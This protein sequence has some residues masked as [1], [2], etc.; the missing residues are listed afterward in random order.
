MNTDI[1]KLLWTL[2]VGVILLVSC[3]TPS[4]DDK[5]QSE[6][7]PIL[8]W[9]S[10]LGDEVTKD[11]YV[12]MREAGFNISFSHFRTAEQVEKALNESNGTGV[13]ILMTCKE[14][15]K[16]P[17]KTVAR[18]KDHPNLIGY[19]LRDEPTCKEFD[20][21]AAWA[22]RIKKVDS[23]KLL[24]LNLFPNYASL[25]HLG[26]KTYLD[27]VKRF[28]KEVKLGL[29][30]FD[31]YPIC[32]KGVRPEFYAN[33][34][35]IAKAAK[36][37]GEPFWAFALSTAHDPYPVPT[38]AHI[39]FQIFSNLAYGAQG[40]QYFTYTTPVGSRWNFHNAPIDENGKKTEVYDVIA[41][42]NKE[43]HALT[44]VFLGAEVLNVRHTGDMIP[45]G[46]KAL[47]DG[48]KNV[49]PS[50]FGRLESEGD[51]L[52]VSHFKN[53]QHEY[54]ML[55]NKSIE[56]EQNVRFCGLGEDL[57]KAFQKGSAVKRVMPNGS[58]VPASDYESSLAIAPGD[59]LLL[60][61]K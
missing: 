1:K 41:K 37:A 14:L 55:V 51:G 24:Y 33:L 5:P 7:F 2:A 44:D 28:I 17:E 22:E 25:G 47:Y 49:L 23:S 13:K 54:L 46:T 60:Q 9:F 29:V 57:P 39:R 27:Y 3:S 53:G 30:S 61:L 38:D 19:F 8:A 34:E 52:V 4:I 26:V 10:L 56:K 12:E 18:F 36:A 21:L 43:V 31:H 58:R 59:I 35:D 50:E 11:R 20:E 16:E 40:L 45:E 48:G 15:E 32:F 42:V 6:E